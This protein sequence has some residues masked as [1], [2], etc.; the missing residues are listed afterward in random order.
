[1]ATPPLGR[2]YRRDLRVA[3]TRLAPKT[4][5]VPFAAQ[6]SQATIRTMSSDTFGLNPPQQKALVRK[7]LY[8]T[9]LAFFVAGSAILVN[10]ELAQETLLGVDAELAQILGGAFM[11]VGVSDFLIAHL[12]FKES[13]HR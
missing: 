2:K 3:S 12:F 11:F 6:P 10:P 8:I 1:M 5:Y 13:D 7:I 9:G 4:A